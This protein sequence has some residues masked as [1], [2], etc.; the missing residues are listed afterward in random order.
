MTYRAASLH[1]DVAD[2][3][4]ALDWLGQDA[5]ADADRIAVFGHSRGGTSGLLAAA[6]D[7]R[8]KAVVAIAAVSD[9]GEYLRR[10]S[11]F[12]P[13]VRDGVMQFVGG[14]P[15]AVP[16][17]YETTSALNA[18]KRIRQPVLLIHGAADMRV[19]LDF[20]VAMETALRSAGNEQVQLE[21]IPGMGHYLEMS[22]LGYQFDRVCDLTAAWLKPL[23]D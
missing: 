14:S 19:P 17:Q 23:L 8:I 11:E 15:D 13:A 18:A 10:V 21:V 1:G 5:D 4:L 20:S 2:I 12:A 6:A 7:A 3:G 22:T 16:D 9:L